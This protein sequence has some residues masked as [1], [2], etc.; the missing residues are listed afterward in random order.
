MKNIAAIITACFLVA[1]VVNAEESGTGC[2]AIKQAA[3]SDGLDLSVAPSPE[4]LKT[5]AQVYAASPSM[6]KCLYPDVSVNHI[7]VGEYEDAADELSA[8]T[9]TGRVEYSWGAHKLQQA[10]LNAPAGFSISS[11]P[12]PSG[13]VVVEATRQEPVD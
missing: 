3:L 4:A 6:G 10:V 8:V 5:A 13:Q 9:L 12:L 2:A 7:P 1:P 11:Y